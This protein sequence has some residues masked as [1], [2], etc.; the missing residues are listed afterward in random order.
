MKIELLYFDGCPNHE[1]LLPQ[2]RSVLEREGVEEE[3]QLRRVESP[4]AAESERFLGSPTLRI[5]GDDVEPDAN[6]R[7]DFGLKCRLYRSPEGMS[8]LPPEVWI[9][10]T[11]RRQAG[12]LSNEWVRRPTPD[13]R[14][15]LAQTS[16]CRQG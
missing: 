6:V 12:G 13:S 11:L 14:Q 5:D 16:D 1:V 10:E 7:T 9:V 8:G 3:I 4:D 2:L 15:L